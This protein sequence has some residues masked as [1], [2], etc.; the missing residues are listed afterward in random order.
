VGA[1][2]ERLRPGRWTHPGGGTGELPTGRWLCSGAGSA[3]ALHGRAERAPDGIGGASI[4]TVAYP[5][6][7]PARE[8]V[9]CW[10]LD[11]LERIV[12]AALS[13]PDAS[14]FGL[15]GVSNLESTKH[16]AF[17]AFIQYPF[18]SCP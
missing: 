6:K 4:R 15:V 14:S 17:G 11:C 13:I 10:N 18:S 8:R 9:F 16:L 1:H 12:R 7:K 3:A 5:T 2:L